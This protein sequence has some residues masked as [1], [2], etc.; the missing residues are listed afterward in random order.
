MNFTQKAIQLHNLLALPSLFTRPT[1]NREPLMDYFRLHVVTFTKYLGILHKKTI[2]KTTS[3]EHKKAMR[4]R[5]ENRTRKAIEVVVV[6]QPIANWHVKAQ[7]DAT[8]IIIT[9]KNVG[10][11]FHKNSKWGSVH[12]YWDTKV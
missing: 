7:F 8:W 1:Q 4:R 5:E 11:G 9:I 12:S 3:K 6:T 2:D 10:S